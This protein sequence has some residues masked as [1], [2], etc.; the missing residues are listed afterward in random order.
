[1]PD[2]EFEQPGLLPADMREAYAVIYAPSRQRK[3]YPENT[4]F[5]QDSAETALAQADADKKMYAAK[6]CGP[7]RSSEGF[8]LY[9]LVNWLDDGDES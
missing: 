6:V 7:F 3:R 9:Y 2:F 4:V 5:V 1:M 8:R